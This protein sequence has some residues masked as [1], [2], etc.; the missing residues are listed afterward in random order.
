M[1]SFK[2]THRRRRIS[3]FFGTF[4]YPK[5]SAHNLQLLKKSAK[6]VWDCDLFTLIPIGVFGNSRDGF[7]LCRI[8]DLRYETAGRIRCTPR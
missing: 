8:N 7:L 4:P 2:Q 1:G 5:I 6:V 3:A